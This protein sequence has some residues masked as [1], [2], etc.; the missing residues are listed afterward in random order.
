MCDAVVLIGVATLSKGL[1][2]HFAC[3]R[4]DTMGGADVEGEILVGGSDVGACIA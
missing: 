2:A 1:V 3:K 4:F